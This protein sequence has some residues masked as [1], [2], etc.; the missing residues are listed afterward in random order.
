MKNATLI[1]LLSIMIFLGCTKEIPVPVDK[2]YRWK[3]DSNFLF[4]NSIVMNSF[5]TENEL[6]LYGRYFSVLSYDKNSKENVINYG[7][8]GEAN[9]NFK[10]P[11]SP[12]FFISTFQST[13][14]II[15]TLHPVSG[16][17][18]YY[19]IRNVNPNLT[20]TLT[21]PP[22]ELGQCMAI[23]SKNQALIPYTSFDPVTNISSNYFSF[24]LANINVINDGQRAE[25][26]KNQ[27]ITIEDGGYFMSNLFTHKD[28]FVTYLPRKN[29][30]IYP[31]GKF[32]QISPNYTLDKVF[33]R[34]DTLYAVSFDGSL[35][36]S[37]N[38]AEDW[39]K[40]GTLRRDFANVSYYLVNNE[41]IGTYFS[42]LFHFQINGNTVTIKELDNDGLAT[43]YITSVSKF[44]DKVFITTLTGVYTVDFKTFFKYK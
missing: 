19:R 16:G 24:L 38:D 12:S 44:K 1:T 9:N 17:E 2:Q 26:T 29:Y 13:V 32:K 34:G 25:M 6:Y 20:N 30:K 42:Q 11:I 23:N 39:S 22:Y 3:V 14:I 41:V 33:Q 35:L 7:L 8:R 28:Y 18:L 10:M 37:T 43:R 4:N 36:R 21:L 27:I 31:D 40:M 5:A 15:P